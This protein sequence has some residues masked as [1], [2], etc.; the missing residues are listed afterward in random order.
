GVAALWQETHNTVRAL[1]CVVQGHCV[2]TF[3]ECVPGASVMCASSIPK[4]P[5]SAEPYAAR[6]C[7]SRRVCTHA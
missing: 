7:T 2:L 4:V 3:S 5:A 1:A 6:E